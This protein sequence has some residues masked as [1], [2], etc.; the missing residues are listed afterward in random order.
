VTCAFSHDV[1]IKSVYLSHWLCNSKQ[2]SN[3]S[4]G[5]VLDTFPQRNSTTSLVMAS[6]ETVRCVPALMLPST[7]TRVSESERLQLPK[8]NNPFS[9][10]SDQDKRNLVTLDAQRSFLEY[11]LDS[12]NNMLSI[13]N[14]TI[15][16]DVR[17]VIEKRQREA[18][19]GIK[20]VLAKIEQIKRRPCL[21][22]PS[23]MD[24][25]MLIVRIRSLRAEMPR[26]YKNPKVLENQKLFLSSMEQ[27]ATS[28]GIELDE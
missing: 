19:E 28:R 2:N 5:P 12:Y 27:E 17:A 16:D 7:T 3:A 14:N 10:L 20:A 21:E 4:T 13:Q 1:R 23:L 26:W 8:Q 6:L 15:V 22:A 18:L 11:E 25:N 9:V 24:N